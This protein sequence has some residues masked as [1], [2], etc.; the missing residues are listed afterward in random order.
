MT[1]AREIGRA[2]DVAAE[3]MIRSHREWYE[4][5]IQE[6]ERRLAAVEERERKV[7]EVERLVAEKRDRIE[8][9]IA[10]NA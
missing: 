4:A 1:A 3:A 7:T 2:V 5:A 6:I 9:A 8:R 10:A